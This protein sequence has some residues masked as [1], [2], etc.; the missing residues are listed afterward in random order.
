MLKNVRKWAIAL[1]LVF[2]LFILAGC[3]AECPEC[4]APTKSECTE[5]FPCPE[6]ADPTQAQCDALYPNADCPTNSTFGKLKSVINL[7]L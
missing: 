2:G 5:L 3:N 7:Q 1:V 6:Q 4:E